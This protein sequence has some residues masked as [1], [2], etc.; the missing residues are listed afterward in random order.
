MTLHAQQQIALLSIPDQFSNQWHNICLGNQ[1]IK[2]TSKVNVPIEGPKVRW[3]CLINWKKIKSKTNFFII[4]HLYFWRLIKKSLF[5]TLGIY[6][7][8]LFIINFTFF[9]SNI[10]FLTFFFCSL[11]ETN[12]ILINKYIRSIFF[13]LIIFP[14]FHTTFI[15]HFILLSSLISSFLSQFFFSFS[16]FIK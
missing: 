13:V 4:F 9:V 15:T 7:S 10:L 16:H 11:L 8:T 3:L 12:I 2:E 1:I 5:I 6:N 14:I